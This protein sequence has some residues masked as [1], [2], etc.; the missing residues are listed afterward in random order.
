M[1]R[2]P[3]AT[4]C[5]A[6]LGLAGVMLSACWEGNFDQRERVD[7]EE[8]RGRAFD[9]INSNPAGGFGKVFGVATTA[10]PVRAGRVSLYPVS[11]TGAIE[12]G[13]ED[14]LGNGM[15][16]VVS[17][18]FSATL[19]RAYRGPAGRLV[20]KALFRCPGPSG[21]DGRTSGLA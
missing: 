18:A 2:I 12:D 5:F 20:A 11:P 6:A 16:S 9:G 4:T 15:S 1:S 8:I 10:G 19:R 14:T 21:R 13:D 7:I 3:V 17:G